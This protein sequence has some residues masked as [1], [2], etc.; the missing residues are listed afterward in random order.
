[1]STSI[2]KIRCFLYVF[3]VCIQLRFFRTDFS[4]VLGE[5]QLRC[6]CPWKVAVSKK[7]H[8]S[9]KNVQCLCFFLGDGAQAIT[10]WWTHAQKVWWCFPVSMINM[11]TKFVEKRQ[12]RAPAKPKMSLCSA[13]SLVKRIVCHSVRCLQLSLKNCNF[14]TI[15]KLIKLSTKSQVHWIASFLHLWKNRLS[16]PSPASWQVSFMHGP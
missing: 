15:S 14:Q 9:F 5:L 6:P 7:N 1:M 8:A 13:V 16:I 3:C 10:R 4:V 11:L 12:F 2:I